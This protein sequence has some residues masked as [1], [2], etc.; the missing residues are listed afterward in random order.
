MKRRVEATLPVMT[1]CKIII[2]QEKKKKKV[3]KMLYVQA[4]N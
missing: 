4:E 2:K 3:R 1:S